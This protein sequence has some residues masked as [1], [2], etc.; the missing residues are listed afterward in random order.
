MCTREVGGETVEFGTSGYTHNSVFVL[1]DRTTRSVWHP[2]TAHTL[3]AVSGA[4]QG[5]SLQLLAEPAPTPL[6]EW[7]ALHPAT[8]VLLPSEDDAAVIC[9]E[10]EEEGSSEEDDE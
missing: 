5:D 7:V 6:S 9:G 1:Y 3:D 2:M 10:V 4:R 8:T